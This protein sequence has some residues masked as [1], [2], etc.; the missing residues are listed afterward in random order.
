[1]SLLG[2]VLGALV[3]TWALREA[4][5]L[6]APPAPAPRAAGPQARADALHFTMTGLGGAGDKSQ[7]YEPVERQPWTPMQLD[8]VCRT[9]AI[10]RRGVEIAARAA[11]AQGWRVRAADEPEDP[12]ATMW[13]DLGVQPVLRAGLRWARQYGGRVVLMVTDDAADQRALREEMRPGAKL[14]RLI[15]V[16]R[17]EATAIEWDG[18]VL[19][20]WYRQPLRWLVTPT[21]GTPSVW[22]ASRVLYI[23]GD[24]VP[25]ERYVYGDGYHLSVLE[26]ARDP[27]ARYEAVAQA[28][29]VLGQDMSQSIMK[30]A[31]LGAAALAG[32]GPEALRARMQAFARARSLLGIGVLDKEDDYAV[33]DHTVAGFEALW[34]TAKEDVA[35]AFETPQS[36]LF[37]DAPSGLNTDGESGR[38]NWRDVITS[39]QNDRLMGPLTRL[40]EVSFAALGRSPRAWEIVFNPLDEPSAMETAN[41]RKIHAETDKIWIDAGVLAAD[42]VARSRFQATGYNADIEPF[43]PADDPAYADLEAARIAAAAAARELAESGPE[44]EARVPQGADDAGDE[45]D[46]GEE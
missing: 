39:E 21:G 5:A 34:R 4:P 11:T 22:H 30:I 17:T 29:A 43:D 24:A 27:I 13:G 15:D 1:M 40:A 3:P 36:L 19:S 2:T 16:G 35:M 12:L 28:A 7:S 32:G 8:Q 9:S 45:S 26:A 10:A 38:S 33:F 25:P 14:K 31:D 42:H 46:G 6:D 41:I 44:D 20:R 18:D 37:G 23:P